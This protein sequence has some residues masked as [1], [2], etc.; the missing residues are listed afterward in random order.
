MTDPQKPTAGQQRGAKPLGVALIG[1]VGM[2][3]A[4][5]LFQRVPLEESGRTVEVTA[6][7]D[8]SISAR[9]VAGHRYLRAYQDVIG[10]WTACDGIAYVPPGSSYTPAQC[11]AMLEQQLVVHAQAVMNCTPGL[12]SAGHDHQRIAAVLLAYNI[13]GPRYCGSTV[14]ARFNAGNYAGA[15]DAFLRWNKAGGRVVKGLDNRRRREREI[16]RQDLKA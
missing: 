12:R 16:C 5:G 15:C 9:H 2:I 3:G 6:Q 11:D 14:R 1:V 13:G 4:L 8:G 10:V 7:A